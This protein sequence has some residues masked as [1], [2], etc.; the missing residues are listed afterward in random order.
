MSIREVLISRQVINHCSRRVV[1]SILML[2]TIET[3]LV[4]SHL[5]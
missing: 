3:T 5:S 4:E 1:M 2:A